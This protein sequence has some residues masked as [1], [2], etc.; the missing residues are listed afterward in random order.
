MKITISVEV[1][2]RTEGLG[3]EIDE[4]KIKKE[5]AEDPNMETIGKVIKTTINKITDHIVSQISIH[6]EDGEVD[7][8]L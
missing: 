8:E 1:N 4:E 5:H 3:I 2:G 6:K 7:L